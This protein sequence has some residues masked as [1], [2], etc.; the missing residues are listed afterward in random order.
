MAAN[1]VKA[2][3]IISKN[4]IVNG[5][6]QENNGNKY[7]ALVSTD[8]TE[9]KEKNYEEK[10]NKLKALLDKQITAQMIMI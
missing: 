1:S 6:V 5:Y 9:D 7:M 4:V 8:E 3:Y 2:L 10:W